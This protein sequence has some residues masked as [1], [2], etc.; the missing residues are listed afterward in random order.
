MRGSI[1]RR[2]ALEREYYRAAGEL[3]NH[4]DNST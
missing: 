3:D 1:P 2:E 4:G